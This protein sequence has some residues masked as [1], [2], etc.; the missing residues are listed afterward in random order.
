MPVKLTFPKAIDI[1]ADIELHGEDVIVLSDYTLEASCTKDLFNNWKYQNDND[2]IIVS[3]TLNSDILNTK[4]NSTTF[5]IEGLNDIKIKSAGADTN[6]IELG[7]RLLEIIAFSLFKHPLAKAPIAND[8]KIK[9][10]QNDVSASV[11]EQFDT[12]LVIRRSL[13]EQLLQQQPERFNTE[14]TT[15]ADVPIKGTDVVQFLI[16]YGG[17]TKNNLN[18]PASSESID[19]TFS[20]TDIG[21]NVHFTILVKLTID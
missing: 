5:G 1:T 2:N 15:P 8:T 12:D 9:A 16:N 21:K 18:T 6:N 14:S 17:I 7:E 19:F 4:L 11:K 10:K 20:T 3:G 13:V